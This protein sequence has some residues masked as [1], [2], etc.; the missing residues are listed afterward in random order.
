M[1]QLEKRL[2]RKA[3]RNQAISFKRVFLKL[4]QFL[5]LKLL[6]QTFKLKDHTHQIAGHK[7]CEINKRP[8]Y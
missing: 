4:E 5:F 2:L 1:D 7:M 8:I 6:F 3:Y